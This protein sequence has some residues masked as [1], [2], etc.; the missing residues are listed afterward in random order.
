MKTDT[1]TH[2]HTW[3]VLSSSN[4]TALSRSW[5][6]KSLVMG[7]KEACS[8]LSSCPEAVFQTRSWVWRPATMRRSSRK[9]PAAENDNIDAWISSG[10]TCSCLATCFPCASTTCRWRAERHKIIFWKRKSKECTLLPCLQLLLSFVIFLQFFRYSVWA[11]VW[12]IM[13]GEGNAAREKRWASPLLKD[14]GKKSAVSN[15]SLTETERSRDY[16]FCVHSTIF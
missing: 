11:S 4:V 16:L 2:A 12:V 3:T 10:V 8:T 6:K 13:V 14:G 7:V 1:F 15:T 9:K 5:N